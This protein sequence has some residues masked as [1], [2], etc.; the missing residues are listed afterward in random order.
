MTAPIP[1]LF[2]DLTA[3]LEDLHA[4]AVEGQCHEH[5]ADMQIVFTAHLCM[6][7]ASVEA[8]LQQIRRQLGGA[9]A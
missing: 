7:V 3:K 6:G 8:A 9:D 1:R 5:S 4:L 2:A